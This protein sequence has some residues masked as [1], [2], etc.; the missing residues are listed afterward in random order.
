MLMFHVYSLLNLG[1]FAYYNQGS[2]LE[3]GFGTHKRGIINN[4]KMCRNAQ[5]GKLSII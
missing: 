2:F 4:K 5:E 3:K 1:Y